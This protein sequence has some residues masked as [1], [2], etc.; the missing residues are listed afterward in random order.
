MWQLCDGSC[1]LSSPFGTASEA[2]FTMQWG[3]FTFAG[4]HCRRR[5]DPP[6]MDSTS[7][8]IAT[9][10]RISTGATLSF[11]KSTIKF[12]RHSSL[13]TCFVSQIEFESSNSNQRVTADHPD[14]RA[15]FWL[16]FGALLR[17]YWSVL[18]KLGGK[19][20]RQSDH[21]HVRRAESQREQNR[22]SKK[23]RRRRKRAGSRSRT[24]FEAQQQHMT[25]WKSLVTRLVH[26]TRIGLRARLER[27][28]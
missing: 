18:S 1:S 23:A 12:L 22:A 10:E 17:V 8:Y 20:G 5:S 16:R 26:M 24:C 4:I 13:K 2:I 19:G 7:T 11:R 6:E 28:L 25:R 9:S 3:G 15:F 27:T 14:H 21:R